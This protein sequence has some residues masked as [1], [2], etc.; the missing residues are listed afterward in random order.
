MSTANLDTAIIA[1]SRWI[2]CFISARPE[3]NVAPFDT[4]VLK[5]TNKEFLMKGARR[6]AGFM[7]HEFIATSDRGLVAKNDIEG[8]DWTSR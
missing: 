1:L 7:G 3:I 2:H 5:P 4:D 6:E 8:S